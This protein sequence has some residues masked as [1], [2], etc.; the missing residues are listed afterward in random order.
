MKKALEEEFRVPVRWMEIASRNTH[1]NANKSAEIL[2]ASGIRSVI[3]VG[4][5]FDMPRAKA[6]F[7]AAGLEVTLAPTHL[8]SGTFEGVLDLIPNVSSLQYSYYAL[9]ELLAE[10]ARR[11]GL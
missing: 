8:P 10:A 11:L 2:R 7:A 1:E 3:L 9:Y 4:H 5:S 6:E